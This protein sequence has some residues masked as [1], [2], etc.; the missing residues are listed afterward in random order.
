MLEPGDLI[1]SKYHCFNSAEN[2]FVVYSFFEEK[3]LALVKM[4]HNQMYVIW[5]KVSYLKRI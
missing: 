2:Q 1:D 3:N 4:A 5:Q